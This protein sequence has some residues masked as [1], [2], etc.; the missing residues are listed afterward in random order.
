MSFRCQTDWHASHHCLQ[1]GDSDSSVSLLQWAAASK[2]YAAISKHQIDWLGGFSSSQ[3][4]CLLFKHLPVHWVYFWKLS[5][6]S[7]A[8]FDDF[9]TLR[10]LQSYSNALIDVEFAS[11]AAFGAF[12]WPSLFHYT[13]TVRKTWRCFWMSLILNRQATWNLTRLRQMCCCFD[14]FW[15]K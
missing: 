1:M 6:T 8:I 7:C 4:G 13:L 11:A 5:K 3:S 9:L 10:I 15:P 14:Q 12:G 2:N